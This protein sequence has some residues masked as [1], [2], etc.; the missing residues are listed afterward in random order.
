VEARDVA[1]VDCGIAIHGVRGILP[2]RLLQDA[3]YLLLVA[4]AHIAVG[5]QLTIPALSTEKMKQKIAQLSS[6]ADEIEQRISSYVCYVEGIRNAIKAL[7]KKIEFETYSAGMESEVLSGGEDIAVTVAYFKG[8]IEA[9]NL[10]KLK[11]AGV[12]TEMPA[13]DDNT[14]KSDKFAGMTFVLTGTLPTMTRNEA[15]EIIKANGGKA[16][17]SVSK[18]TTYVLAGADAGSKLTK[19]QELGVTIISED[20]FMEMVRG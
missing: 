8:Y 17:G 14:E 10:D 16:A 9:D 5:Y 6:R 13:S 19:A 11:K 2:C 15:A 1:Y 7:E 18:K 4:L 3:A 20:E 12:V